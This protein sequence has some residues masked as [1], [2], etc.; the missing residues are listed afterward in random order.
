MCVCI[1]YEIKQKNPN[2]VCPE[3]FYYEDDILEKAL[4]DILNKHHK[5]KVVDVD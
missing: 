5:E 2:L 1:L 3:V 4:E